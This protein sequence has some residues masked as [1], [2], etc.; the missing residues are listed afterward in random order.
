MNMQQKHRHQGYVCV[1][2][3]QCRATITASRENILTK[4]NVD[5]VATRP[6]GNF[7]LEFVTLLL[8]SGESEINGIGR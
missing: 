4:R 2:I 7:E 3:L 1:Y 6:Y 5:I 8:L